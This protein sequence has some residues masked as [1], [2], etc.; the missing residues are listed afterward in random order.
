M[1]KSEKKSIKNTRI[2]EENNNDINELSTSN[3][4]ITKEKY[5]NG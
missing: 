2:K 5:G 3:E 1:E 4:T